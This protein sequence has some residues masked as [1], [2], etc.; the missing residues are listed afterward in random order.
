VVAVTI[1]LLLAKQPSDN[2]VAILV[3]ELFVFF[4]QHRHLPEKNSANEAGHR[5]VMMRST[6]VLPAAL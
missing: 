3:V 1:Y 2:G 6:N 5:T 4:R